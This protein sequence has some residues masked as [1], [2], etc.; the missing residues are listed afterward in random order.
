MT[1]RLP[2]LAFIA[3]VSLQ[4]SIL[5]AVPAR[6]ALTLSSGR[7]VTLKVLPVDPY[8]LLSGYYVRLGYEI[9]QVSS[10]ANG[11]Q[12][13][14]KERVYALL[15][16]GSDGQWRPVSL[17]RELPAGVP[18]NQVVIYGQLYYSLIYYGI[19]DFYIPERQREM[20]ADDLRA[21]PDSAFVEVKIDG[22]GNAAL[23][24]L[25]I[26]DRVYE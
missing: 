26:E 4:V 19:E 1:K 13:D 5:I 21:H 14:D 9:S 12:F 23:E 20:I 18:E 11:S 16:R 24:R 25:R 17:A 22:A 15:E 7:G 3:A 8:N 10:F 6:R 2:L